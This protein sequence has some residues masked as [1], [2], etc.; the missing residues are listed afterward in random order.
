MGKRWVD[1]APRINIEDIPKVDRTQIVGWPDPGNLM[2][3]GQRV[4]VEKIP[5]FYGPLELGATSLRGIEIK[6]YCLT[7]MDTAGF[8]PKFFGV[9]VEPDCYLIVTEYVEGVD[10]YISSEDREVRVASVFLNSVYDGGVTRYQYTSSEL[11]IVEQSVLD[12]ANQLWTFVKDRN[13]WPVNFQ[14]R[15]SSNRLKLIIEAFHN[16]GNVLAFQNSYESFLALLS[17]R[18]SKIR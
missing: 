12:A 16:G 18:V 13:L 4:S 10:V 11:P 1:I 7:Y 3:D 8:G 15:I 5:T 17:S 9:V 14:L 2:L 6:A